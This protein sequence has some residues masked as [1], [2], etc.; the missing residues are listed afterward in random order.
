MKIS[1]YRKCLTLITVI[2]LPMTPLTFGQDGGAARGERK[3]DHN[4]TPCHG[5][6]IG[7]DGHAMLPGTEALW[8]KYQGAIPALLEERTD[9]TA[10]VIK[11][12]LRN[13]SWSMPP[14]RPTE[15]TDND[16]RDIAAYL[17]ESS[18]AADR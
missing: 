10:E 9:L 11:V 5:A 2:G 12:Y 17:A 7:D 1:R 15:I 8:I 3:F 16:I 13:G 18:A 6:G 4:C 14:F